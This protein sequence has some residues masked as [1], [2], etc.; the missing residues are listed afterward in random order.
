MVYNTAANAPCKA[1]AAEE[2]MPI[3]SRTSAVMMAETVATEQVTGDA[4][5]EAVSGKNDASAAPAAMKDTTIDLNTLRRST[6]VGTIIPKVAGYSFR[7]N[8]KDTAN[9][10]IMINVP[11]IILIGSECSPDCHHGQLVCKILS[12]LGKILDMQGKIPEMELLT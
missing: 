3:S 8:Q 9:A 1:A 4:G 7:T 11:Y 10:G 2:W 5:T 12:R 6:Q